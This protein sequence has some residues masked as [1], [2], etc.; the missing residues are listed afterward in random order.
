MF[1]MELKL[2]S[3]VG[4][5][6]RQVQFFLTPI[7]MRWKAFPLHSIDRTAHTSPGEVRAYL[8]SPLLPQH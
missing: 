1:Y 6:M 2:L 3:V 8:F 5:Q 4:Q 7:P